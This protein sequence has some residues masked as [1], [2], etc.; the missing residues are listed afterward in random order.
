MKIELPDT[1]A[2]RPAIWIGAALVAVA[3][4]VILWFN[5][6][7]ADEPVTVATPKPPPEA[8]RAAREFASTLPVSGSI[9][10]YAGSDSCRDCHRDEHES[11]SSSYHSTMTQIMT[12]N[13][14]RADFDGVIMH[15][16]GERFELER[17][18]N[19]FW[20]TITDL[21]PPAGEPPAQVRYRLGLVTGSH[22]MQVFWFPPG[23][24]NLQLG[25]PFTWLIDDERWV[26]RESA[27]VR[28]PS[29]PPQREVWNY[30]C[31]RCH[32][33]AGRPRPN[34]LRDVFETDAA[35]LGISCE[36][37]HGPAREHVALRRAAERDGNVSTDAVRDDPIV[38]PRDLNH[39]RGSQVCGSCHSMKWFEANAEWKASGFQYRPGDNLE[40][41]TPVIR[42]TQLET[43]PWLES[44][45]AGNPGLLRDF[46][47]SD[48]M[49][50]VAGREYNGLVESP[51]FVGGE[52]S[53]MSCH[54]MHRSDPDDQLGRSMEG[55]RACLQCHSDFE[56]T[57]ESHTRHAP[58][59]AG[60]L[61]YNCHMPHTSYALLKAVRSH[62]IDSPSV[63]ATLET[64]RPNA[65]NLCHLDKTLSW[66]SDQLV[67]WFGHAA[68]DV[69]DDAV[70]VASGV[71]W[72]LSGDA[73]QRA[74]AAW[75]FG[76]EPALAASGHGWQAP[77][78]GV[79]LEDP[80]SAVRYIAGKALSRQPGF[81][82]IDY[83]FLG[84]E[85]ELAAARAETMARWSASS[86]DVITA[87][88]RAVL[89]NSD[90]DLLVDRV[91]DLLIRRDRRPLRLRE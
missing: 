12:T 39:V 59:S 28:D 44:V 1:G 31:I 66:T 74:L 53:C 29:A 38:Q 21:E 52:L 86:R 64:G 43:Q 83:D 71:T 30:V 65:C 68:V 15:H 67:R 47:W 91:S 75:H 41:T 82:D 14:V 4:L 46:F 54:S 33:T 20:V 17:K 5:R 26:P 8:D 18:E 51:C 76:W 80:Y 69:P 85:S 45:L 81:A 55:N 34:Y 2:R 58:D 90:G 35:E 24:G 49:I 77:F 37:C 61:C 56:S 13:T 57:L 78:L 62:Q 87:E 7:T 84:S 70:E 89:L 22:H 27:F 6:R 25:F 11:W 23:A 16:Q 73:G 72:L 79:L 60:S 19:E 10:E 3:I 63:G 88:K 36:A 50:R 9:P 40:A 32:A 42:P 48:G